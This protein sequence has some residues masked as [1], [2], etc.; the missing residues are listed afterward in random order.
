M[1][2]CADRHVVRRHSD[3]RYGR[4]VRPEFGSDLRFTLGG[5]ESGWTVRRPAG[6]GCGRTDG[7]RLPELA[8][9][10][11]HIHRGGS[12][13]QRDLDRYRCALAEATGP[14]EA[15][16]REFSCLG[17]VRA[18]G[19][20]VV[21]AEP[22]ECAVRRCHAARGRPVSERADAFD[23]G[24]RASVPARRGSGAGGEIACRKRGK[25]PQAGGG[26][27]GWRVCDPGAARGLRQSRAR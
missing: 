17:P 5:T 6:S 15:R 1:V 19:F 18:P 2:W 14:A 9:R 3:H 13:P 4:S 20:A 23:L 24:F 27:A 11:R 22:A 21:D 8:W 16:A 25:I 26:I 10:G 12:D 7:D